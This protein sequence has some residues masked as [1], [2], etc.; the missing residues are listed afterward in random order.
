MRHAGGRRPPKA[1]L[2]YPGSCPRLPPGL[3]AGTR[4]GQ[5]EKLASPDPKRTA[6]LEVG[7]GR[8]AALHSSFYDRKPSGTATSLRALDRKLC[9]VEEA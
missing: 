1:E 9:G 7:C 3:V 8:W 5:R 6:G 4:R 2:P